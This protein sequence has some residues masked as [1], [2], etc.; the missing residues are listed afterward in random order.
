MPSQNYYSPLTVSVNIVKWYVQNY[1]SPL[2]VSVNIVK[3]YM[4]SYGVQS[5]I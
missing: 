3:W 4:C 2:T 5:Y 1:Y